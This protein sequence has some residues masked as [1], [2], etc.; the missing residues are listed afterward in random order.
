MMNKQASPMAGLFTVRSNPDPGLNKQV[1]ENP[2]LFPDPNAAMQT[3]SGTS[4]SP[5]YGGAGVRQLGSVQQ[6][7]RMQSGNQGQQQPLQQSILRTLWN[8]GQMTPQGMQRQKAVAPA[9]AAA[10]T[11]ADAGARQ[12]PNGMMKPMVAAGAPGMASQQDISAAQNAA[13]PNA[14]QGRMPNQVI[15]KKQIPR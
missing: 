15:V 9:A 1:L 13:T 11:F 12:S 8:G 14:L 5:L 10:N 6:A 2:E 3:M 4:G 7:N